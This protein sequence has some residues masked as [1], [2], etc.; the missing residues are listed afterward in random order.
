MVAAGWVYGRTSNTITIGDGRIVTADQA[1]RPYALPI[2]RY[3]D[4]YAV[5]RP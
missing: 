4:T 5:A 3:E 1:G 2:K